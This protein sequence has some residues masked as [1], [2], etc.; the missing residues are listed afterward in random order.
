MTAPGHKPVLVEEVIEVLAPVDGAVILDGTYGGGGYARAV[1]AVADCTVLAVDRDPEAMQRAWAHAGRDPRLVPAPGHFGL[2]DAIAR[3]AGREAVDGVMLDLG[4]SSY[5][6]DEG[7]RGFSFMR[8]GPL[9]MRMDKRGPTAADV[10]NNAAE[11]D[12]VG[13]LQHLGEET[14][15]RRIVRTLSARR[16]ERPFETTLDLAETIEAAVGGRRGARTHPATK[17]FQALRMYVNDEA[18]ELARALAAAERAL[19]PGGRLAVVSFHSIEDRLVKTFLRQRSGDMPGVS[20]HLPGAMAGPAPTF[21]VLQRKPVEPGDAET[22]SNPRARSAKLR[23][24]LR[25]SA[26][27]WPAG[28]E[29]DPKLPGLRQLEGAAS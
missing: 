6:I 27:S 18:G 23:W 25:T 7:E 19:K 17:S 2:L 15:A 4:V 22:D 24:A 10:V 20:R 3:A 1:L 16:K 13:I 28:A 5:Q 21:E 29:T 8:D 9:D 11:G 26:P 12:L 14:Q